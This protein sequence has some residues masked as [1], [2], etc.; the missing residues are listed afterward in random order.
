[1]RNLAYIGHM[2]TVEEGAADLDVG[3]KIFTRLNVARGLPVPVAIH[4]RYDG[5]VPGSRERTVTRCR[6][7]K[8]AIEA[9]YPD[10]M[11]AGWLVCGMTVQAKKPGSDL[12][13]V[14]DNDINAHGH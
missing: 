10:L 4:Y 12:E 13:T 5:Q 11:R 7:V 3:I 2:H 8:A 6:R 9:R 14:A 1:L